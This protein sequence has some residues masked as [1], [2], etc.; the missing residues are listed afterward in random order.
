MFSLRLLNPAQKPIQ[1]L[2]KI[3]A[4]MAAYIWAKY[5]NEV[6]SFAIG[7]EPDWHSY[8]ISDP[9]IY[10]RVP[11][12]PGSAYPSYLA[13]WRGF[14]G[15]VM[16][17]APK[18]RFSGPE[19]GAYSRLTYTPDSAT[20]VSWTEKFAGDERD[21]GRIAQITQHLYVGGAP[22]A[23]TPDQAISNMLSPEWVNG[24]APGSQPSGTVYTPYPWL[25][26]SNLAHVARAAC[27]TGSPNRTTTS[28]AFTERA[29]C[30]PRR[31]GRLTTCI[32][33]QHGGQPELTS[34]TSSGS[35]RTRSCPQRPAA[36]RSTRK[37][38]ASK[39]SPWDPLGTSSPLRSLMLTA[40]TYGLLHRQIR[41]GLRH[42]HQQDPRRRRRG[43]PRDDR[44]TRPRAAGSRGHGSHQRGSG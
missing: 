10:E 28:A 5:Q 30:S 7:N 32:G 20:G 44:T 22:G 40:S 1:G 8:H 3:D 21:S 37:G 19:T 11:P 27:P 2:K 42:D 24:I 17:M 4:E 31:C 16:S 36:M 15:T 29:M 23:T 38:T 39:R 14:A 12:V 43:R 33:G 41:H 9:A 34:T 13:D 6:A 18:A 35:T 25:Y 26:A